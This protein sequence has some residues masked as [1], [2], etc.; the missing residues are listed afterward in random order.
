MERVERHRR[1]DRLG[2]S[3]GI[4]KPK[5]TS[6]VKC[7]HNSFEAAL[8]AVTEITFHQDVFSGGRPAAK[9]GAKL[10]AKL[11]VR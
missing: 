9:I 6:L 2:S 10:S 4:P 5:D 11:P 3:V 7:S 8:D 1:K